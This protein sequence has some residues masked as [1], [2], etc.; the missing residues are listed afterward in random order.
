MDLDI[1]SVFEVIEY[2]DEYEE[3]DDYADFL[4]ES[5]K[6]AYGFEDCNN[7]MV[8]KI[9]ERSYEITFINDPV[10]TKPIND[11]YVSTNANN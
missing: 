8:R 5:S 11:L 4:I 3:F 7:V 2:I 9:T 6:T 10:E 1:D